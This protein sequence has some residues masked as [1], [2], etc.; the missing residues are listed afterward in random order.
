MVLDENALYDAVDGKRIGGAAL[1]VYESEPYEPK[2]PRR[3]L[4][5]L[6]NVVLTPHVGSNTRE[7]NGRMARASLGNVRRFLSGRLDQLDRVD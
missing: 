1:D 2:D 7:A 3:D 6:D 4:R 5:R